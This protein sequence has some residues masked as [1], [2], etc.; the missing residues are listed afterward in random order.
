MTP[1]LDVLLPTNSGV[2]TYPPGAT[3]GPRLL[4][5]YEFV[6]MIE[7]DAEY[8]R[9]EESVDAPAGSV[10][11]CRPGATD[12]F[13]WDRHRRTRHG[14]FHFGVAV[15]PSDWPPPERWPVVRPLPAE[16]ILRPLFRHLLTWRGREAEGQCR[17]TVAHILSVF[18]SGEVGTGN[19]THA[20]WPD[21]VERAC[22]FLG[23]ALEDDPARP[24]S[25]KQLAD[26]AC[27][28]P[29][30]LCRLFRATLGRPPVE[31]V[32]LARLDRAAGLLLRSNY[33]VSEVSA[34][35]GFASPFHFS[36]VFKKAYGQSPTEARRAVK[37]GLPLP[38]SPLPHQFP[39]WN[40]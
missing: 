39:S 28:T 1:G 35:Y 8:R 29:E 26:A 32:R 6:W 9:G 21:A 16:D 17:L 13:H 33:T 7:G 34:L 20:A 36:R 31:T 12:F 30:H 11:L 15:L 38:P 25:L 37:A 40:G 14:F 3:Y 22:A 23:R 24:L 5:D 4:R 27:V 10:V 19:P 18:I 2:A